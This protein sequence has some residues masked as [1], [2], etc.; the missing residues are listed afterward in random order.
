MPHYVHAFRTPQPVK[1]H[2]VGETG[3]GIHPDLLSHQL[4]Y[5]TLPSSAKLK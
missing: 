4:F 3:Q 1:D 5:N 2:F